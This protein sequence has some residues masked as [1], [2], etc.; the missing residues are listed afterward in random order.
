M[1]DRDFTFTSNYTNK[2]LLIKY[3]A[4][5]SHSTKSINFVY[6]M[7]ISLSSQSMERFIYK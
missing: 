4:N 5:K 1:P 3:V 7:E 2:I 6:R